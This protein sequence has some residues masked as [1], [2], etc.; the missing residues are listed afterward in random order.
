MY[1]GISVYYLGSIIYEIKNKCTQMLGKT[2]VDRASVTLQ[3]LNH[4]PRKTGILTIP[5]N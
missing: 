2:G 1:M 3:T 5:E 4:E